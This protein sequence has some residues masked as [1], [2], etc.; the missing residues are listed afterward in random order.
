MRRG[1]R[2]DALVWFPGAVAEAHEAAQLPL[3][4]VDAV[5]HEVILDVVHYV[6][7]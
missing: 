4:R 5:V 1:R 7:G 3:E 2:R 6:V